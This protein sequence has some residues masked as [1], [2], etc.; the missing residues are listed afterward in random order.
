M[1]KIL[2]N[3]YKGTELAKEIVRQEVAMYHTLQPA[4]TSVSR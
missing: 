4:L 1:Q 3:N 2:L